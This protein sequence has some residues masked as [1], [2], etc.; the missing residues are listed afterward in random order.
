MSALPEGMS[1]YFI[2]LEETKLFYPKS[3]QNVVSAIKIQM[4]MC[5]DVANNVVHVEDILD[6]HN[7][8][9]TSTETVRYNARIRRNYI[10]RD[11]KIRLADFNEVKNG[12]TWMKC[13]TQ[14]YH[15]TDKAG[16]F[17]NK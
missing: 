6:M 1:I 14:G 13:F 8:D 7:V 3:G 9:N 15:K 11:L 4:N 10:A 5:F 17:K 12:F 16:I 2:S